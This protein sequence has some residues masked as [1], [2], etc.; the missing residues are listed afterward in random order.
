MNILKYIPVGMLYGIL[1]EGIARLGSYIR[2]K[3]ANDTGSDDA[4]GN[5]LLSLAPAVSSW[6]DSNENAK[7]KALKAARDT[8]DN[9][10][11]QPAP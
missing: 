8:I 11:R 7:R 1:G 10:L 4:F 5:V 9:Y 3:D 2:G 6:E